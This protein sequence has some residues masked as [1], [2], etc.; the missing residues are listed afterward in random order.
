MSLINWMPQVSNLAF[1]LRAIGLENFLLNCLRCI[2]GKLIAEG[3]STLQSSWDFVLY[4]C[5]PWKED[6]IQRH[7]LPAKIFSN[8]CPNQVSPHIIFLS[9]VQW[10]A[11]FSVPPPLALS[12][13]IYY[14]QERALSSLIFNPIYESNSSCEHFYFCFFFFKFFSVLE[15]PRLLFTALTREEKFLETALYLDGVFSR[16]RNSEQH[17]KTT[18]AKLLWSWMATSN[19]A[20][21]GPGPSGPPII[22]RDCSTVTCDVYSMPN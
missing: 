15:S 8:D 3:L 22:H 7:H 21:L 17:V 16:R 11:S 1:T 10:G 2:W 14:I 18:C 6:R 9:W 4:T 12:I 19:G 13:T 5:C 20:V